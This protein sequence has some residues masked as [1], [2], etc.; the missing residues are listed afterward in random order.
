MAKIQP[1]VGIDIGSSKITTLIASPSEEGEAVHVVGAATVESRGIKK[2]QVVDI[3]EAIRAIQD[4]VEAAERMA[5]M[6]VSKA[7]IGVSGNNIKCRNSIGVVAVAEPEGEITSED[8]TRVI[9]AARAV[10]L[11]SAEEIIHVLPRSYKVDSQEGV[12]D[13]VGM[14]GVRLEAEAHLVTGSSTA[15]RNLSKCVNELGVDLQGLVFAGLCASESVLTQTERE[16]GVVLVDLG[17][18]TTSIAV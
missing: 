8:V 4:S 14:T 6:S 11:S 13:P 5:G 1:V 3:E 12:K 15:M 16:L 7:Y 2:S 10:S 18:G 17:G 9:E